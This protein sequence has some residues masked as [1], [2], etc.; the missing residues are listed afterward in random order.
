MEKARKIVIF[1]SSVAAGQYVSHPWR[2]LLAADLGE[3]FEVVDCSLSGSSTKVALQRVNQVAE[4]N[5]DDVIVSLSLPNESMDVQAF[6]EGILN[7]QK[8]LQVC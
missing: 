7:L 2:T 4:E 6:K 8:S 5:P 3:A 1:G